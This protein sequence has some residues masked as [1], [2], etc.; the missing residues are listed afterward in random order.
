MLRIVREQGGEGWGAVVVGE[1]GSVQTYL[2]IVQSCMVVIR[3]FLVLCHSRGERVQGV[4]CGGGG[5]LSAD[6]PCYCPELHGSYPK[7]PGT[8]PQR[9]DAHVEV[10]EILSY[11]SVMSN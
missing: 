1:G 5:G 6:L 4:W 3:Q 8:L 10:L 7:V 9:A 11:E 2:V